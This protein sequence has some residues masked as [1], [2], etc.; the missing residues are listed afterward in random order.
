MASTSRRATRSSVRA[1]PAPSVD[2][3]EPAAAVT[4]RAAAPS[5][6]RT[7]GVRQTPLP[8]TSSTLAATSNTPLLGTASV[9]RPAA[10]RR[11]LGKADSAMA[12]TSDVF[13][14]G[15]GQVASLVAATRARRS[16]SRLSA[17]GRP[18]ST[19][20]SSSTAAGLSQP[21][22][23]TVEEE[24]ADETVL[25]AD[26]LREADGELESAVATPDALSSI[27]GHSTRLLSHYFG[28]LVRPMPEN[29]PDVY[30]PDM[31]EA[32][33]VVAPA[34]ALDAA[35]YQ[36]P[37]PA[38]RELRV[39]NA[40]IFLRGVWLTDDELADGGVVRP[41]KVRDFADAWRVFL[42]VFAGPGGVALD[43][44]VLGLLLDLSTQVR[45]PFSLSALLPA[46]PVLT[47]ITYSCAQLYLLKVRT[48][49]SRS[50][51]ARNTLLEQLFPPALVSSWAGEGAGAARWRLLCQQRVKEVRLPP[52]CVCS[53]SAPLTLVPALP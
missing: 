53:V 20:A 11:R 7:D 50:T 24:E 1:S 44:D 27:L 18:T 40:A 28:T 3:D 2:E 39:A 25:G 52:H 15:A 13:G 30:Y 16:T 17:A 47:P 42:D 38:Q 45:T 5:R 12:S 6:R 32:L 49:V 41:E 29:L 31:L 10:L 51:R 8:A 36:L 43:E 33:S 9:S 48:T 26:K 46:G 23:A 21:V 14:A 19:L 35:P 4:P 22:P 37:S 34:Q